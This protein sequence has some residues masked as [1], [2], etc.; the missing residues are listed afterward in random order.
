MGGMVKTM[1]LLLWAAVW[2]FP[3]NPKYKVHVDDHSTLFLRRCTWATYVSLL[4][5]IE[6]M[7]YFVY[8]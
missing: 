2:L 5:P 1:M 6:N 7:C 3:L 4:V 8:C